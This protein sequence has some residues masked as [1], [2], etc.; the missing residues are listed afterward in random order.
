[1]I[2]VLLADDH[3]MILEGLCALLENEKEIE[4]I[5]K[6]QDGLEVLEQLKSLQPHL[7]ILDINMPQMDGIELTAKLKERHP[8]IKVLILSMH[9]RSEFIK[10]LMELGADGYILKNSGRGELI[11]AIKTIVAGKKYFSHEIMKTNF[12][13]QLHSTSKNPSLLSEREKDVLRLIAQGLTSQQIASKLNISQH[14]VD[15]H[16]KHIL[17]KIE[18]KNSV[19]IVKYALKTGLVKGF[20]I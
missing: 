1:M 11:T 19:D 16:R 7:L 15:S 20:D 10:R 18:A 17:S 9:N 3:E 8:K 2:K 12:D 13:D 14:T 4:I 5:G 6:A